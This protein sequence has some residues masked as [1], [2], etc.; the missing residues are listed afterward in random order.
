[1]PN[2]TRVTTWPCL[3]TLTLLFVAGTASITS[4]QDKVTPDEA[5]AIAKEAYLFSYPLVMMYRT[6]NLQAIDAKSK[7]YS[8]G[9]GK[10]LHLETSSPKDT[11]IVTPNNDSP[12]SPLLY[13]PVFH[14][15]VILTQTEG[16]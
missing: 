6:M 3:F 5:R 12:Y 14:S 13:Y 1:M 9:F 15:W 2:K 8:G 10:W 7:S 11:D 4:A 16:R